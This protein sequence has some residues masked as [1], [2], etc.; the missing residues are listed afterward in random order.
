MLKEMFDAGHAGV[1]NAFKTIVLSGGLDLKV[2]GADL[3]KSDLRNVQA[4]GETRIAAAA[5]VP[6]VIVGLSEGLQAATYAN[7]SQARRRFADGTM[8]PLWRIAASSLETI[9]PPPPG[10][11]LTVDDRDI[12]FLREDNKD[13]AEIQSTNAQTIKALVDAGFEP[14]AVV[15]AVMSGDLTTIGQAH[16]GLYSV[17]LQ[18]PGTATPAI[19][20]LTP[21]GLA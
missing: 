17:Q 1:A 18:P 15:K 21:G 13:A 12:A 8:R 6:P 14:G 11:Y 19:P 10:A 20:A 9:C 3:Q 7:Y 4:Q 2:I 16:T 5:G